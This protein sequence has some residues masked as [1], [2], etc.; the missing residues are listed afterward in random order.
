MPTDPEQY[1]QDQS[2]YSREYGDVRK[3]NWAT[4]HFKDRLFDGDIT[5]SIYRTLRDYENCA[6]QLKLT[7]TPLAEYF[8]NILAERARTY[9]YN[10]VQFGMT[11]SDIAAMMRE[12]N[13]SHS[14]QRMVQHELE[15][16]TLAKFM[17]ENDISSTSVG[18]TELIDRLH[19][20][21]PQCPPNFRYDA[22]KLN[23]LRSAVKG[24]SWAKNSVTNITSHKYD[25]KRFVTSLQESLQIEEAFS[26]AS[27][28]QPT[29]HTESMLN[30]DQQVL[31]QRNGRDPRGLKK[32]YNPRQPSNSFTKT[33]FAPKASQ[34]S[35]MQAG[36]ISFEEGRRR[37]IC[38]RC[39]Q[40]WKAGHRCAPGSIQIH[41]ASAPQTANTL[42]TS[43]LTLYKTWK[44]K[45]RQIIK[46]LTSLQKHRYIGLIRLTPILTYPF[47]TT[48]LGLFNMSL[49]SNTM[50]DMPKLPQK[51][52]NGPRIMSMLPCRVPISALFISL[53]LHR[54]QSRHPTMHRARH[55][56][57]A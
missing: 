11:Y 20:M 48:R 15:N 13:N 18:L 4:S 34:N 46:N 14:R 3:G 51:T 37:K 44:P 12:G 27:G 55:R 9:F 56:I 2:Y 39:Q 40:P 24:L 30:P 41:S 25:F 1:K 21:T 54:T 42:C 8:V 52:P 17:D 50:S 38:F 32:H 36:T 26:T 33:P 45:Q 47:L 19:Q 28:D 7:P 31:Y 22:H 49:N 57:F 35:P 23:Y 10:N 6:R 43:Y 5:Q 53:T 29:H 16:L